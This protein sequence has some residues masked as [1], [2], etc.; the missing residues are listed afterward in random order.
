MFKYFR[1][2][3]CLPDLELKNVCGFDMKKKVLKL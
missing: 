1:K 3:L 2:R